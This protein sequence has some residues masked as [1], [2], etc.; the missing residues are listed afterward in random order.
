MVPG[1]VCDT[2]LRVSRFHEFQLV[3]DVQS[4]AAASGSFEDGGSNGA[5]FGNGEPETSTQ[6]R[7]SEMVYPSI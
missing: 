1:T 3:I 6:T 4:T 5:G 7:L 2:C